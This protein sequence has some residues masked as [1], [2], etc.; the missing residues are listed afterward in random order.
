MKTT[1]TPAAAEPTPSRKRP[2]ARS[3]ET[4]AERV[5]ISRSVVVQH[6]VALAQREPISE[7]S[8]VRLGRELGVTPG[9][10]HYYVG[11]RDD[12]I[13]AV[14][15]HAFRERLDALPPLT[16]NWRRDLEAVARVSQQMHARWPGLSTYA[17]TH[18]RFRLFQR[19]EPGETD[20]GLAFFN[21]VGSI[22]RSGGFSA[23]QAAFAYHLLM[24]LLVSIGA[25]SAQRQMPGEHEEFI[26]GYVSKADAKAMPGA[27]FLAKPFARIDAQSTLEVGLK[28]LLDGFEGWLSGSDVPGL[29]HAS[30][31][32][33]AR[34]DRKARSD[35]N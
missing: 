24:L 5:E 27:S 17:A 23:E 29:S 28:I 20:Y 18:N 10:I 30:P 19:V 2:A 21:H 8:I 25:S 9:L 22:L 13:T 4:R 34:G 3:T 35:L 31:R 7:I 16:G 12:L 11:S 32:G 26:V 15:N 1:K 6:A 14:M 33:T